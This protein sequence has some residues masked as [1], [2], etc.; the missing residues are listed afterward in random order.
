MKTTQQSLT[1]NIELDTLGEC[2]VTFDLKI[3]KYPSREESGHGT[4]WYNE[5]E[6]EI[7]LTSV[8]D[9]TNKNILK[10]L[11]DEKK[12]QIIKLLNY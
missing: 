1:N 5:D 3:T 4:H 8:V 6:I 9:V 2:I 11:T 10:L 12:E 7:I